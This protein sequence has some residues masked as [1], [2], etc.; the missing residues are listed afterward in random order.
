MSLVER[1][2]RRVSAA[3]IGTVCAGALV[4]VFAQGAEK[5]VPATTKP[6]EPVASVG[7]LVAEAGAEDGGPSLFSGGVD[8]SVTTDFADELKPRLFTHRITPSVGY[9]IKDW[10][11]V[12]VETTYFFKSVGNAVSRYPEDSGLSSVTPSISRGNLLKLPN[13]LGGEHDLSAAV[14]GDIPFSEEA[15]IEGYYGA[16]GA[17]PRLRSKFWD[18]ILTITNRVN[19]N[20][21]FN[22]YSF[23]PVSFDPSAEGSY[24]YTLGLSVKI[25]GGLRAGVGFGARRTRYVDGFHDFSYQNT[26][27]LSFAWKGWSASIEHKN[28]GYTD[29]EKV[30]LWYVDRYR[31]LVTGTIGY[32]F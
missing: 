23:S 16:V 11:N 24:G 32:A 25:I 4:S 31:R 15:R 8:Y 27:T 28:G 29:D 14:F 21:I 5:S 20:F 26:Q 30:E 9:E 10:F 12:G 2:Q 17:G 13:V 1:M 6:S 18:G 7:T 22:R 19:Y 3:V